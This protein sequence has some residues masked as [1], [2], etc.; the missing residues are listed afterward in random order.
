MTGQA[1]AT[2]RLVPRLG[3]DLPR[4]FYRVG[5]VVHVAPELNLF[6]HQRTLLLGHD[7]TGATELADFAWD[8]GLTPAARTQAMR[9]V[10]R[11]ALVQVASRPYEFAPLVVAELPGWADAQG[12][13]PFW[14]GLGRHFYDGD[15]AEAARRLGGAAWRAHVAELLPRQPVYLSF[16]PAAAQQVVGQSATTVTWLRE[17]LEDEGL[18]HRGHLRVDDA[19]PVLEAEASLLPAARERTQR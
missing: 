19:G 12:A 17:L 1:L 5:H 15:P 11:A 18:R 16:L 4:P 14:S 13:S 2:L 10:V 9:A 6:Q 8:A 3:L 7:L